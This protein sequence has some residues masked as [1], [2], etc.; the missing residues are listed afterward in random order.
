MVGA[1]A[2][3]GEVTAVMTCWVV[4]W[5]DV[6]P[7]SISYDTVD[8]DEDW[9]TGSNLGLMSVLIGAGHARITPELARRIENKRKKTL[10]HATPTFRFFAYYYFILRLTAS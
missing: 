10:F 2:P 8:T 5:K 9:F 7:G 6:S 1:V 3:A 4:I